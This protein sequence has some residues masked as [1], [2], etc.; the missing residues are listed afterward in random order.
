MDLYTHQCTTWVGLNLQTV[1]FVFSRPDLNDVL[2]SPSRCRITFEGLGQSPVSSTVTGQLKCSHDTSKSYAIRYT[3]LSDN[4]RELLVAKEGKQ[5]DPARP[6]TILMASTLRQCV[7]EQH[8]MLGNITNLK[9]NP[10]DVVQRWLPTPAQVKEAR[11]HLGLSMTDFDDQTGTTPSMESPELRE[12]AF[13]YVDTQTEETV[14][15]FF[16]A[17]TAYNENRGAR[18][19]LTSKATAQFLYRNH[20]NGR[21]ELA[22][23]QT[24]TDPYDERMSLS[25]DDS[26]GQISTEMYIPH[27]PLPNFINLASYDPR[28]YIRYKRRTGTSSTFELDTCFERTTMQ[29]S[30][31]SPDIAFGYRY[32]YRDAICTEQHQKVTTLGVMQ[33]KHDPLDPPELEWA[34]DKPRHFSLLYNPDGTITY[35]LSKYEGIPP[36]IYVASSK[37]SNRFVMYPCHIS[38]A[39]RGYWRIL[40]RRRVPNRLGTS[41]GATSEV[42][43]TPDSFDPQRRTNPCLLFNSWYP[44]NT[45]LH[46]DVYTNFVGDVDLGSSYTLNFIRSEGSL[47]GWKRDVMYTSALAPRQYRFVVIIRNNR[48]ILRSSDCLIGT[49]GCN[50]YPTFPPS[51]LE[52]GVEEITFESCT[53]DTTDGLFGEYDDAGG[54]YFSFQPVTPTSHAERKTSVPYLGYEVY[55]KFNL[56]AQEFEQTITD[57]LQ[58]DSV[59]TRRF[60]F[61]VNFGG[62][63]VAI[64]Q[65]PDAPQTLLGHVTDTRFASEIRKLQVRQFNPQVDTWPLLVGT[66]R[67]PEAFICANHTSIRRDT[68]TVFETPYPENGIAYVQNYITSTNNR[69]NMVHYTVASRN[70]VQFLTRVLRDRASGTYFFDNMEG[71]ITSFNV[72][73]FNRADAGNV[74]ISESLVIAEPCRATTATPFVGRFSA[75]PVVLPQ[76]ADFDHFDRSWGELLEHAEEPF[77]ETCMYWTSNWTSSGVASSYYVINGY[78]QQLRCNFYFEST[79]WTG[80]VTA[81]PG[82]PETRCSFGLDKPLVRFYYHVSPAGFV[83]LSISKS[84]PQAL[85]HFRRTPTEDTLTVLLPRCFRTGERLLGPRVYELIDESSNSKTILIVAHDKEPNAYNLISADFEE[86]GVL[87]LLDSF[88]MQYQVYNNLDPGDIVH[89]VYSIAPGDQIRIAYPR[90]ADSPK[91]ITTESARSIRIKIIPALASVSTPPIVGKWA[92]SNTMN[93]AECFD[94]VDRSSRSTVPRASAEIHYSPSNPNPAGN[95]SSNEVEIVYVDDFFIDR[96]R[97][98]RTEASQRTGTHEVFTF[99]YATDPNTGDAVITR[100]LRNV[101]INPSFP[102]FEV[103]DP[104]GGVVQYR[105]KACS[106]RYEFTLLLDV[107]AGNAES[108]DDLARVKFVSNLSLTTRIRSARFLRQR[109][110]IVDSRTIEFSFALIESY[111]VD[112]DEDVATVQ[113]LENEQIRTDQIFIIKS[114]QTHVNTSLLPNKSPPPTYLGWLAITAPV[115]T[116]LVIGIF[117]LCRYNKYRSML[118]KQDE[119][120]ANIYYERIEAARAHTQNAMIQQQWLTMFMQRSYSD[121]GTRNS[122]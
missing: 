55:E 62:I 93:G 85:P 117:A 19:A 12:F 102:S 100:S 91:V 115:V 52:P 46:G 73:P 15:E 79:S 14:V 49:P 120:E 44:L 104:S 25:F 87:T 6:D 113:Q 76:P 58:P 29:P 5:P 92:L 94:F 81:P 50:S 77:D 70:P 48:L 26:S 105:Y 20:P 61:H 119:Y 40:S 112:I 34:D 7:F 47:R 32:I 66:Y 11:E 31:L 23:M 37:N 63:M 89:G 30:E 75:T 53:W 106:K 108:F 84:D 56:T 97:G 72:E 65:S 80:F 60:A 96:T 59:Q 98:L 38:R 109:I 88:R 24:G 33:C 41:E 45:T 39:L 54:E 114:V 86:F 64:E 121:P 2:P 3:V 4:R 116:V 122:P 101:V 10:A 36:N 90:S 78:Q 51:P 82:E 67:H 27:V 16:F 107:P 71:K 1:E 99:T 17:G 13:S 28:F 74:S 103:T 118:R 21:V 110:R 68:A 69:A 57:T 8:H 35:V 9:L 22:V 42:E 43:D 83:V 111:H 18:I 95:S